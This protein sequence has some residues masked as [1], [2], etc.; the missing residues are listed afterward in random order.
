MK[1]VGC[2]FK[3][4]I[5]LMLLAI[6]P[7]VLFFVASALGLYGLSIGIIGALLAYTSPK[8]RRWL[9][10][11]HGY[12][13]RLS[14]LPGM[15][16]SSPKTLA[17]TTM[18]Y[19][20]PASLLSW[21]LLLPVFGDSE[22]TIPLVI[23]GFIGAIPLYGWLVKGWGLK[24]ASPQPQFTEQIQQTRYLDRISQLHQVQQL[25]PVAFENF[26]GSLFQKMGYQVQTTSLSGD[27]GIDLI[28]RKGTKLA[29]VQC[30]RY[31]NSVGQPTIRDLY[32]VM[33]HTRA[34]EAYLV[35]TGTVTLPA[36]Q[37]AVGKPIHLVD[38][39]TLIEW[40]E[41]L[42]EQ[43]ATPTQNAAPEV[44]ETTTEEDHI[45]LIDYFK[46]NPIAFVAVPLAIACPIYCLIAGAWIGQIVG[47]G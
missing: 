47:G 27:Q 14:K 30:K 42:K 25:D 20:V 1:T 4:F 39:N 43:E 7:Y 29:V 36:Q 22:M 9:S 37:W 44:Y 32:G 16:S 23:M 3:I 15:S 12:Q 38:G 34:D 19:M 11:Q 28:L 24:T 45:S 6:A 18:A 2:V 13:R 41:T 33:V 8:Y 10:N 17:I 26:V 35:T 5:I 31:A 46:Q 21:G 40:I